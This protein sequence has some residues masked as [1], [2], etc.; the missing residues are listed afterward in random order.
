MELLLPTVMIVSG[1]VL[2]VAGAEA[3]VKGAASLAKKMSISEIAIALTVVAFGTSAP[4]LVVNTFAASGG[5]HDIV[6]GNVIGSNMANTLLVLGVAGLIYPLSVQKNTV[7]KEIPFLL[8]ATFAVFLLVHDLWR[9]A[10]AGDLLSRNDG[11][12]LLG[13]LAIFLIYTFGISRLKSTDEYEVTTYSYWASTLM[14]I[15]GLVVL[16]FGGRFTVN[17]A[18]D[19]ARQFGISEKLI[20]CTIIAGGTSMPE[21][22]TS[23]V[24]AYR[25]RCDIAVGNVVGSCIFNLL[26]VLGCSGVVRPVAYSPAFNIDSLALI[27]AT[28]ILFLTMFTGK[29]RKLDRWEAA[30]LLLGYVAYIGYLVHGR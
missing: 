16:F 29:R 11:L 26:L 23:A 14:I 12:I 25:K 30:L 27:A 4:E 19:V 15:G 20:A 1:L 6:F 18:V 3:M 17:G 24:A 7:W 8:L 9:G 21:L 5:Q 22:V 10:D 2:L 28:V 13:F